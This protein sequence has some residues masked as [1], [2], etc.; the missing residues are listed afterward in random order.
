MA[1]RIVKW[2]RSEEGYVESKCGRFDIVPLWMGTTR[3]Q[4][5]DLIDT[6]P[7]RNLYVR[8]MHDTQRLAKEH[9]Q[10]IINQ[11]R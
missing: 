1:G 6:G 5:Y 7:N 3:A 9:A 8:T 4:A 10:E 2:G 11:Q